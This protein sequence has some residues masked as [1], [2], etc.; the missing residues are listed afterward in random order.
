MAVVQRLSQQIG[1]VLGGV[2]VLAMTA[3]ASSSS[4]PHTK[5]HDAASYNVQLGIAYL[6]QGD[7]AIA[8]DKLDRALKQNPADP[9]VH[10]ALALLYERLGKPDQ[11]DDEFRTA[12]RL[13]PHDP[14]IL[15]NYAIY[16]CR[17]GRTED[18]V[19]HFQEAATNALYRTP[20][21]AYTN[22][23]VCLRGAKRDLEAGQK[24]KQAL[25]I[26][27]N[28]AEAAY[29]LVDLDFTRGELH[30]A[31]TQLDRYLSSFDATPDL[32]LLGVR[33]TRALG[34][35]LAAEKYARRLRLDFPRS[36]QAH[37]LSE[38]DRNPG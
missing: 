23:G 4:G 36:D 17:S 32:L 1:L 22:A 26:R 25:S 21:A 27:P 15:N 13:G 14:D 5:Q 7:L 8:K 33:V 18:G 6:H 24:F 30:D 10:S 16:L 37:A 28:Y 19:K 9:N 35:R 2:A 31:R 38:L 11:A 12:L 20:E 3:C 34:D 29:Q